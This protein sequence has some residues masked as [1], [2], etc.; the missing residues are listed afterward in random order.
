MKTHLA[1]LPICL[2]LAG[3]SPSQGIDI[4]V[5]NT[6]EITYASDI[7]DIS[8]DWSAG[9]V[10]IRSNGDGKIYL[11]DPDDLTCLGELSLPPGIQGFGLNVKDEYPNSRYFVNS[12]EEAVI[13]HC[14]GGD[15]WASFPNPALDCGSGLDCN[16]LGGEWTLFQATRTPPFSLYAISGDYSDF[17]TY[18]LPGVTGEISGVMVH[19]VVT[20]GDY[21]PFGLIGTTRYGGEFLFWHA[22][23][24]EY[25]LYGQENCPVPVTESLGL[26]WD[27]MHFTVFWSYRGTDD[28]YY[29]SELEIPVF[30]GIEDG[31]LP[32]ENQPF[33]SVAEN[34]ACG[35]LKLSV[36]LPAPERISLGVYDTSGRLREMLHD[37][38]LEEQSRSW[39]ASLPVGVYTAVLNGES[40]RET[41]RFA[42]I[43]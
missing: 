10:A 12:T 5:L 28:C 32:L 24:G 4:T 13:Y 21:Q 39:N 33:L 15:S 29:V 37:G 42:V 17:V 11:A 9:R 26:F 36:S 3:A 31:A 38:F 27:W 8:F 1:A 7:Q 14:D 20:S 30:G 16:S 22:S 23:G 40:V 25:V 6:W 18:E 19:E 2:V 43:E 34:P 41:L 35:E